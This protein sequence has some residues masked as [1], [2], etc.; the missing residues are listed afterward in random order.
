MKKTDNIKKNWLAIKTK[1]KKK[2]EILTEQ[3]LN[4]LSNKPEE[5]LVRLQKR[6]GK[7]REEMQKLI[8][9]L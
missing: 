8:S 4:G 6:L 2:F 5:L 9:E 7:T 3:D 1:L